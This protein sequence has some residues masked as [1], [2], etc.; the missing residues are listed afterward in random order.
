MVRHN[1]IIFNALIS[2][3]SGPGVAEHRQWE[4]AAGSK[5]AF[6]FLCGSCAPKLVIILVCNYRHVDV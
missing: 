5:Y 6:W 4:K 3:L 1:A 2:G